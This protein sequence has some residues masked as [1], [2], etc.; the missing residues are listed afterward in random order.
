MKAAVVYK[1]QEPLR[2]EEMSVP[3]P[4]EDQVLVKILTRCPG[5]NAGFLRP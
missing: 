4:G 3:E 2:L 1:F 5:F